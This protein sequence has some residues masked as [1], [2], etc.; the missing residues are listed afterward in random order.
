M[1][2][3][4]SYVWKALRGFGKSGKIKKLANFEKVPESKGK[5]E[6]KRQAST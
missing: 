4:L 5:D 6:F 2:I 3:K 1:Q